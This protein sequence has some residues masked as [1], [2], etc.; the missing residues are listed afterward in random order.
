[1]DLNKIYSTKRTGKNTVQEQ[2]RSIYRRDYDRIIFSSAFRRLQNKTQ[3]FPLPGSIFVHNRLTHSLEVS[4][5]GRS[6]GAIAG[7]YIASKYPADLSPESREFYL[8]DLQDVIAAAC[9]CHDIGNPSFGHSGE[10]AIAEYFREKEQDCAFKNGFSEAHWADLTNFEGNANAIRCLTSQQSGKESGGLGLTYPTLA[11]IIKYPCAS[12]AINKKIIHRK[13]FG[14]LQADKEVFLEIAAE[15]GMKKDP[16]KD[17]QSPENHADI[18]CRHPFVWLV[19]AAD[20]ICYNIIDLEDAHRLRI[21]EHNECVDVLLNLLNEQDI[22]R[23][24]QI[25][26]RLTAI[27]DKNAQI[28]YLRAKSIN[29]LIYRTGELFKENLDKILSGTL[30]CAL[31]DLIKASNS[32]LSYIGKFSVENIYNHRSVVE[33]ENAGYNVMRGLLQHFIPPI[34]K[35]EHHRRKIEDKA[36]KLIPRQFLFDTESPYMKVL[37]VIDYISGMTDNYAVDLYKRIKGIDMGMN[38]GSMSFSK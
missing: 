13:K 20:D 22:S 31:Y 3:V 4:S 7:E 26:E 25:R 32:S 1:M 37:G 27:E 30:D 19:E 34:L 18:Y 17:A 29:Y 12:T 35:P 33:I 10:D 28:S 11:S 36:V 38:S 2:S 8:H 14:Y 15:T 24:G 5:V 6:L 23:S 21:I 16:A 9:L